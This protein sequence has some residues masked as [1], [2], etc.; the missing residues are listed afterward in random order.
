MSMGLTPPGE[1]GGGQ[2]RGG[3]E[4]GKDGCVGEE[5]EVYTLAALRNRAR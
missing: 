4:G 5:R 2:G 1:R 3:R